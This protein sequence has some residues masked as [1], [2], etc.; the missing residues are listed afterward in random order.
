MEYGRIESFDIVCSGSNFIEISKFLSTVV[1]RIN[2]KDDT[3]VS[4][5]EGGIRESA[6]RSGIDNDSIDERR[7]NEE[8]VVFWVSVWWNESI[9]RN[10]QDI[11]VVLIRRSV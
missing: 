3:R 6:M 8:T 9:I 2:I 10:E 1:R 5:N 11:N 4:N 7:R